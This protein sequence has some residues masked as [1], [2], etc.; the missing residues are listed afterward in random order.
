MRYFITIVAAQIILAIN[1]ILD[2]NAEEIP[3]LTELGLPS[4]TGGEEMVIFCAPCHS[5]KLVAQQG[6]SRDA[7]EETIQWMYDEHEMEPMEPTDH[8]LVLDYLS[9]Y[10][11]IEANLAKRERN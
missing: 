8:K 9:K 6:L 7:W 1:S 10:I 3:E 2:L 5:L 4:D 11:S